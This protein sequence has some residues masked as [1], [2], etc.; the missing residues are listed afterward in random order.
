MKKESTSQSINTSSA[1]F[2]VMRVPTY[3]TVQHCRAYEFAKRIIFLSV[4]FV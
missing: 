3:W 2:F 1:I 4:Q